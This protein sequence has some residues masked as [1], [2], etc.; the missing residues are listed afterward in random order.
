MDG[1]GGAQQQAVAA[2]EGATTHEAAQPAQRP[3]GKHA[4][5]AY[6]APALVLDGDGWSGHRSKLDHPN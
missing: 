1:G 6:D 2:R 5:L 3:I 4:V